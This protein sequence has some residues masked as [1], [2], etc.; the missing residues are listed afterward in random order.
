MK[1]PILLRSKKAQIRGVDFAVSLLLFLILLSQVILIIV[2][3][4]IIVEGRNEL[5]RDDIDYLAKRLLKD[6]GTPGWGYVEGNFDYTFDKF[7]LKDERFPWIT[8][9]AYL[10]PGKLGRLN[11]DG[12]SLYDSYRS[13]NLNHDYYFPNYTVIRNSVAEEKLD[14]SFKTLLPLSIKIQLADEFERDLAFTVSYTGTDLRAAGT[15]LDLFWV[16][17]GNG[18]VNHRSTYVT[19]NT[20]QVT[21]VNAMDT[22]IREP[23]IVLAICTSAVDHGLAWYVPDIFARFDMPIDAEGPFLS[24][25]GCSKNGSTAIITDAFVSSAFAVAG[26]K[27]HTVSLIYDFN[28]SFVHEAVID[29]KDITKVLIDK[30]HVIPEQGLVVAVSAAYYDNEYYFKVQV[31]PTI[32]NDDGKTD[33]PVF[34]V[35][36]TTEYDLNDVNINNILTGVYLAS[37]R[38]VT[39]LVSINAWKSPL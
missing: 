34:P 19:N 8:S 36:T 2:N 11:S 17:L 9:T 29:T 4:Q 33:Y 15:K 13:G 1:L 14:F 18:T 3:A 6:E 10:D 25:I 26:S 39:L 23:F 12:K 35:F 38:N 37:C 30:E 5:N 22:A 31:L 28:N 21:V 32:L 16:F 20:G 24:F 27:N 7:G